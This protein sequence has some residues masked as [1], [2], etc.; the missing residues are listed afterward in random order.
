MRF[1]LKN[2]TRNVLH[3]PILSG[4]FVVTAGV[5][6]GSVFNYLLQVFLGRTLSIP[7]YGVFN[8]LLSFSV[9]LGVLG[10]AFRNSVVKKVAS[11]KSK[12]DFQTLTHLFWSL[13]F[14]CLLFG[15]IFTLLLFSARN[16]IAEF[17]HIS[18][19][20][21]IV[22]FSFFMGLTFLSAMPNAYLQGLLR[23]KA[24][25]F[26]NIVSSVLRFVLPVGLV[27]WGFG[28]GGVFG[29]MVL[30]VLI[31]YGISYFLLNKNF[32]KHDRK[33]DLAF[34]YKSLLNFIGPLVFLQVGLTLLNNVD[35]ILVK[36]LF[37][38][39]S[40]GIYAGVVTIGKILLFGAGA[41]STVMFPHIA[42]TFSQGKDPKK[43]L[44]TYLYLQV[45]LIIAGVSVFSLFPRLVTVIMFGERFLPAVQYIP[46]F[47][48]FIGLYVMINFF[49]LY[50]MA[51]EKFSLAYVLGLGVVLQAGLIWFIADSLRSVVVVNVLVSFVIL[52][53]LIGYY[54]FADSSVPKRALL[55]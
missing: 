13:S 24:L 25:A 34:H 10:G 14:H 40:A 51:I 43:A 35:V 31:S 53:L 48:I 41:V 6:F 23:F 21:A 37:D 38:A 18:D 11:L 49:I 15:L 1:H 55:D 54:L 50:F 7:D 5:L 17:F 12:N 45:L 9:I 26:F 30:G 19:I 16:L 2:T 32:E 52:F 4:T 44:K 20:Q 33:E 42:E 22:T 36:R 28:V 3:D 46:L 27:L 8:T 47:S 29:G 39:D